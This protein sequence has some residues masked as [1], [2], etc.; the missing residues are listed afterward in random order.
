MS[1]GLCSLAAGVLLLLTAITG[2]PALAQKP[3]GILRMY[4]LRMP[5]GFCANAV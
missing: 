3:G 2:D 1:R 5:P 4:I